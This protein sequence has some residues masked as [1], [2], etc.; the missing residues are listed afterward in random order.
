MKKILFQGGRVVSDSDRTP[1]PA[2]VLVED[3][4]IAAVEPRLE[5]YHS[6]Q[7]IDCGG[8]LLLP[9]LFDMHVHLRE[10]GREDKETIET[11]SDAALNGGVTGLL[12]MPNTDP[13]IDS[14]GMVRFVYNLAR[15]K[16]RVAVYT[17]GCI[18]RGRAGKEL[19]EIGDM[20]EK[21]AVMITD[22]GDPVSDPR[23]LRRAME[24]ARNFRLL[25]GSHCEVREL[26]ESGAVNEG[27]ISYRLGLPGIPAVSEEICIERDLRIAQWTRA[28]IH[29]QHLSTAG[30]LEIVRR[31]K[32]AGVQA[33]CEVTPQHLIFSESDIAE[34]DT[35]FKMN[36]PL[37]RAEDRSRLLEGLK[38]GTIDCLATDHAPHNSFEK[39]QDFCGAP[40]GVIGLDTAL[41]SIH[42]HFIRSEKLTWDVIARCFSTAPRKLLGLE[43]AAIRRNNRADFVVFDPEARTRVDRNF[44]KSKSC[45]TPFLGRELWGSVEKVVVGGDLALDRRTDERRPVPCYSE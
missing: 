16:S 41:I 10:P 15:E 39:N 24:Y 12:A 14:G 27:A 8:R 26:S 1:Q 13:A 9:G 29:I 20:F 21:G 25:V 17:A 23:L 3:G 2:D 11:G 42:T 22:D 35:N 32:E 18:S 40:F 36:P 19:A 45:N 31:F 43:D 6:M 33:S 7:V 37:R 4:R 5:P 30:G 28:R 38:D 34:Y 44:I